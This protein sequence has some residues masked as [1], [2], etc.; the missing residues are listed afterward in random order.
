MPRVARII[1]PGYPY[2]ITQRGNNRQEVFFVDD[3]HRVYLSLLLEQTAKY[4]LTIQ[5]WY[6]MVIIGDCP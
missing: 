5:D 2:H 3:D 6:L 4:Y 1:V